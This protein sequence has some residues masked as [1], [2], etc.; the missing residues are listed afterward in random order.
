MSRKEQITSE[1]IRK[2]NELKSRG[3]N[4]YPH[5]FEKKD[6]TLDLKEKFSPLKKEKKSPYTAKIA[7]RLVNLRDFGKISFG[8]IQDSSGRIQVVFQSPDTPK[9]INE[10]LKKYIDTGDFIGVQGPVFKTKRGELSILVKKAELLSKSLLPL[11]EKW[12]GLQDKEERYRKRH[13]DLIMNPEVKQVF[14]KRTEIIN[15]VRE[16][17]SKK[18]FQ[19]VETPLLQPLYGG[20]EARPFVTELNSLKMRLY[21]SISP[22][23]YLKKLLVGG[24][25]K[26]FTIC[27]N[28]RNEGIDKWHNP[29]F[30]MMEAY[31]SYWDYNEIRKLTESLI[32]DLAKK[33]TGTT[34]VNY[35]EKTIDFKAPFKVMRIEEAIK[36]YS[37]INPNDDKSLKEEAKKIGISG[38]RDEIIEAI[39]D[40]KVAPNLIQPT[41]IIDYPKSLSPLTKE[42]RKNKEEVERFELFINGVEIANAYSELNDPIEQQKRL[43]EQIHSRRNSE[44]LG[45]DVEANVLDEEFIEAMQYGM[46]PAGGVGIGIDRLVLLLTNS[47]SIRDVILFPFMKPLSNQ[48]S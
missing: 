14:L 35:Q 28:F 23:I 37:G 46:P 15:L 34:K 4:P 24:I 39:F 18:G 44:K 17:L 5:Y 40:I 27:K 1:R 26:V 10:L 38:T 42:H 19:E 20:A 9:K 6:S 11:P 7:G 22:E 29:E 33:I 12:H 41:F 43:E 47:N 21:L 13:L 2:L 48:E 36:K 45:P 32:Q 8:E 25:E 3:I 30:T 16:T 31:S